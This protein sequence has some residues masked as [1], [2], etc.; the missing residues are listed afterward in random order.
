MLNKVKLFLAKDSKVNRAI[1]TK[2]SLELI[3]I[4]EG[5]QPTVIIINGFLSKNTNEV[6]DWLEVVDELYPD[7]RVVHAKWDAGNLL[8]V[9]SDKGLLE[10]T[11]PNLLSQNGVA[12]LMAS[13][14]AVGVNKAAGHW[15]NA[16]HE[17]RAVG[18]E[19][20]AAIENTTQ[21]HNCILMGHSLG[22]RVI[23]HT[24]AEL[25]PP[26]VSTAYFLAG[27]VSSEL[28]VWELIFEKHTRTKFINC[29]SQTDS[30]LK[31]GY[32]AG[33]LFDHQ[34]I[35]LSPLG[36]STDLNVINIDA[37]KHAKGHQDFKN[38]RMGQLIRGE[39]TPYSE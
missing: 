30:T 19:L 33:C 36:N 22:A 7:N 28:E 23:H 14:V 2:R 11:S 9:I 38:K 1:D 16:F 26:L 10:T 32:S 31:Y 3:E 13:A 21:L 17:T 29:M 24:M 27:A 5:I 15:K 37:S 35:G 18:V 6:D 25:H 4:R 12:A 39:L 8:D 34:P 20:S